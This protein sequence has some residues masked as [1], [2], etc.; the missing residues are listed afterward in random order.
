MIDVYLFCRRMIN[1]DKKTTDKTSLTPSQ[2]PTETKQPLETNALDKNP[3]NKMQTSGPVIFSPRKIMNEIATKESLETNNVNKVE[4]PKNVETKAKQKSEEAVIRRRQ[5]E[6]E[7]ELPPPLQDRLQD[8]LAG[9]HGAEHRKSVTGEG[10]EGAGSEINVVNMDS[11]VSGRN[12]D[13]RS[14]RKWSLLYYNI[15]DHFAVSVVTI[16]SLS[17]NHS[18]RQFGLVTHVMQVIHMSRTH[19]HLIKICCFV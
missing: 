4:P 12:A 13:F 19:V 7:K 2:N 16:S 17:A 11:V 1:F 18:Y 5:E 14:V 15:E 8:P 10:S 9:R 6:A 3:S